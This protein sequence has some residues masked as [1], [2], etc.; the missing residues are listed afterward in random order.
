MMDKSSENLININ[1]VING[2]YRVGEDEEN[3]IIYWNDGLVNIAY[4]LKLLV[5]D[6]E[7][8]IIF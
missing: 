1:D 5:C 2:H 6:E 4:I 8:A 3:A 7:N